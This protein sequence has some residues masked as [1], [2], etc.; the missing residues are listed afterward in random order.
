MATERASAGDSNT[1]PEVASSG[2]T[3]TCAPASIDS[4]IAAHVSS[5]LAGRSAITGASCRHTITVTG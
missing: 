5:R 4:S 3:T 2:S 1:Y